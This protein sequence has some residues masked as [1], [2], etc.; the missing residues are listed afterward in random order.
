MFAIFILN[1]LYAFIFIVS[2]TIKLKLN[3]PNR[4][5]HNKYILN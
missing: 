2:L 1:I 4:T 5:L 3:T